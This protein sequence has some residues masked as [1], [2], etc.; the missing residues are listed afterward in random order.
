LLHTVRN[1]NTMRDEMNTR[2]PICIKTH[3][4]FQLGVNAYVWALQT[5]FFHLLPLMML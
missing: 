5:W 1:Q 4:I 3:T 2:G